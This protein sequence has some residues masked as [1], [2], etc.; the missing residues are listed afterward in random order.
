[1]PRV[2]NNINAID[3]LNLKEDVLCR[4][5]T[6][7]SKSVDCDKIANVVSNETKSYI[8]GI[9]FKRL[10]GFTKYPYN[11]SYQTLDILCK[12]IGFENWIE[13]LAI[14]NQKSTISEQ[15]ITLYKSI[16]DLD[17]IN[18]VKNYE[19]GIQSISRQIIKKIISAPNSFKIVIDALANNKWAQIFIF[20]HFPIYD[21]LIPFYHYAYIQYL[22]HKKTR[23]AQLFGN[24]ILFLNALWTFDKDE[25]SKRIM[26]INKTGLS[27]EI[28]PF[29]VGRFFA[30]NLYYTHYFTENDTKQLVER[31]I[32][33]EKRIKI[34]NHH[35]KDFPAFHYIV[36]EALLHCN[37]YSEVVTIIDIAF[38]KYQLRR[39]FAKKGYY[40]Q[41]LMFKAD[42]L[43][44]L[45]D[46]NQAELIMKKVNPDNFYFISKKYYTTLYHLI[47]FKI[48]PNKISKDISKRFIIEMQNDFLNKKYQ[49]I[50]GLACF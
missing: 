14:K 8:N 33:F 29:V 20:E 30:S 22:K 47:K 18:D 39:E 5:G 4:Y 17:Y 31:I 1:M 41:M 43:F 49:S 2:A 40:R 23:E 46:K 16:F 45:G 36:S 37:Y 13:Y 21:Y 9:T 34:E 44:E 32:E 12:Y 42:A 7:L 10:F 3:L 26:E 11:P 24:S 19:G 25:A 27:S 50:I 38:N 28:H 6:M 48:N 15:E 35:F